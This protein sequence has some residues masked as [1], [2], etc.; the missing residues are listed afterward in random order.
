MEVHLGHIP[1]VGSEPMQNPPIQGTVLVSNSFIQLNR[2]DSQLPRY[3][4][5]QD[6][7][8]HHSIHLVVKFLLMP[9]FLL[10][11]TQ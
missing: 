3:R 6:K 8:I 1:A 4:L 11:P 7:S 9:V 2:F 10:N 5:H